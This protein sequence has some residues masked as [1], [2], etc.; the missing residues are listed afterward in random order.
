VRLRAAASKHGEQQANNNIPP[1]PSPGFRVSP[2]DP[3]SE[4]GRTVQRVCTDIPQVMIGV[5]VGM[6]LR[7]PNL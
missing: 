4:T 7:D 5:Y 2:F 6:F 1:L 3:M